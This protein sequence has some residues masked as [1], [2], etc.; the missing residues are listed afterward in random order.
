[1]KKTIIILSSATVAAFAVWFSEGRRGVEL[2]RK[3]EELTRTM[4]RLAGFSEAAEGVRFRSRERHSTAEPG[5][6]DIA[7][8]AKA[9]ERS[10]G[11][12][13]I[14]PAATRFLEQI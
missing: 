14:D 12:D 6:Q 8:A 11:P 5:D 2:L 3:E 10:N 1:M 7:D 9:L 13:S 4:N